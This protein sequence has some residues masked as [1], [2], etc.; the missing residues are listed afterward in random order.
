MLS[1]L[2]KLW[3]RLVNVELITIMIWRVRFMKFWS[4]GQWW[5]CWKFVLKEKT[6]FMSYEWDVAMLIDLRETLLGQ[7]YSV[8]VNIRDWTFGWTALILEYNIKA[9]K[10][11]WMA[12]SLL[13]PSKLFSSYF[14]LKKFYSTYFTRKSSSRGHPGSSLLELKGVDTQ[15]SA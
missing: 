14:A 13:L 8:K 4:Q 12:I 1:K 10:W 5:T 3:G 7:G 9:Y 2:D 6:G 11:A 15:E